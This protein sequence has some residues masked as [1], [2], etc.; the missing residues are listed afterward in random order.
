MVQMPPKTTLDDEYEWAMSRV[1][2]PTTGRV[3]D[4]A[5]PTFRERWAEAKLRDI[6]IAILLVGF[7]LPWVILI[8]GIGSLA[9]WDALTGR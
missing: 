2:A 6:L 8:G 5:P 1:E 3:F 4:A 7:V 9:I